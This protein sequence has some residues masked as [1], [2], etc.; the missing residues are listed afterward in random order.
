MSRWSQEAEADQGA[1]KCHERLLHLAEPISPQPQ[2]AEAMKPGD[3][4]LH[5]PADLAQPTSVWRPLLGDE[6]LDA[7]PPQLLPLG[8]RGVRPVRE[9]P[10]GSLP[11]VA[12]L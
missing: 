11:W 4:P 8:L 5:H 3:R 2:L 7:A 9:Q 1:G 6:R 12:R 10:L